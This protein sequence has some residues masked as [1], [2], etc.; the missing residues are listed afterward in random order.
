MKGPLHV[1]VVGCGNVA[2][3]DALQ[4][5]RRIG[6]ANV[7]REMRP[8]V[9]RGSARRACTGPT[10]L[11]QSR[12]GAI[13][14]RQRTG[15]PPERRGRRIVGAR[16]PDSHQAGAAI[17][18]AG[19]LA[20]DPEG[21]VPRPSQPETSTPPATVAAQSRLAAGACRACT[22]P[23]VPCSGRGTAKCRDGSAR[24]VC[25]REQ[26][27]QACQKAVHPRRVL[28]AA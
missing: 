18:H 23:N 7:G 9:R 8:V 14:S 10:A 15:A 22:V 17:P 28:E 21:L 11:R 16:G 1:G 2:V 26:S 20:G 3:R 25:R 24:R 6:G 12:P 5:Q 27:G 13:R 19:G 4:V